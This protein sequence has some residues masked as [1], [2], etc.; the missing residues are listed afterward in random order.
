MDPDATP[1]GL[2]AV[3]ETA[4]RSVEPKQVDPNEVYTVVRGDSVEALDLERFRDAPRRK[5]GTYRPETVESFIAYARRHATDETTVWVSRAGEIVAVLDDHAVEGPDWRQHLVTTA[6][7]QTPEWKHWIGMDG[8]MM[9]QVDFA[10]H[11]ETGLLEI[12]S[13]DAAD[14][15][16]IAQSFQAHTAVEF[17]A[18]NRL[19]SGEQRL[20]YDETVAASAGR[21]GELTVPTVLE[22]AIAPFVGEDPSR[23]EARLRF[24]VN[25]GKLTLG[26]RLERPHQVVDECLA[27][28][29]EKLSAEFAN[30]YAG[31]PPS[32]L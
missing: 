16:E 30:V 2:Q 23:I 13:P 4:R 6:L 7:V 31:D 19:Q 25:G 8:Q 32:D 27:R 10:E 3:I 24:R 29:A 1:T 9:G 28:V 15:L 12:Q 5:K 22:L 18:S 26:Y 20:Q 21:S 17:R 11:I 14:M